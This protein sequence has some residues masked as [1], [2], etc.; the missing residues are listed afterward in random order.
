MSKPGIIACGAYVPRLR[1]A[2]ETIATATGWLRQGRGNARGERSFCNWDEDSIT[3][4]V[5]AARACLDG[6]DGTSLTDVMLA[7]TTL[8]FADRSN[9][10]VVATALDLPAGVGAGDQAGS[11]RAATTA[12]A[13]CLER[14]GA[15]SLVIA[16][17]QRLAKPGS[18]EER[19][20]GHGAA[21]VVTGCRD[22]IAE[23]IAQAT[24]HDD[25]VDHY[26]SAGAAFDYTLEERWVRDEGYAK[27]L[28][29][30]L[31]SALERAAVAPERIDHLVMPGPQ[32]VVRDL[33]RGLGIGADAVAADYADRC[34]DLGN[35]H[36]FLMLCGVLARARPEETIALAT[37]GQGADALVFRVT[38]HIETARRSR[39]ARLEEP[40]VEPH[41]TRFLSHCGLLEMD[42]G[43]RA[44]RDNRTAQSA[45][46]RRL[47]DVTGFVGG[48]CSTCGTVQ[49]PRSRACVNPECRAFDTQAPYRLADS[50]ARV[51]SYTEDWLA[52][53]PRPPAVYGNVGFEEGG[54]AFIE[55]ADAAPGEVSVGVPVSFVFR[56]KD[57]D[58]LRGFRRYFWKAT[59]ERH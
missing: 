29:Q 48:R 1:I 6:V 17:E 32:R 31:R 51:K 5:E 40:I 22:P 7:S 9:A 46:Y 42:R 4:A 10:G 20:Y 55:F 28:P 14:S 18:A 8:P 13:H 45:M 30:V 23:L 56:I 25:L 3:M 27:Q 50:R 19:T 12:L 49:F 59:V 21:A 38:R 57:F 47:R 39:I 33:A 54:N 26:R 58:R 16:S 41:Y 11:Q 37:F 24:Q 35:A 15:T 36:A 2:R 43:M 53:T 34:G 52:F 44:E